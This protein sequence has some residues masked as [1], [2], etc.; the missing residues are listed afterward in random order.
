MKNALIE[1]N[2]R[3][4]IAAVD[5]YSE[6]WGT[7]AQIEV[8]ALLL[9]EILALTVLSAKAYPVVLAGIR[10]GHHVLARERCKKRRCRPCHRWFSD[11]D[12]AHYK[13]PKRAMREFRASLHAFIVK[14]LAQI[15]LTGD[16][17]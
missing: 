3:G 17:R 13:S 1:K 2:L 12:A 6:M 8:Q 4:S 7:P 16:K 14:A 15:D 9:L 11:C 10:E 5:A